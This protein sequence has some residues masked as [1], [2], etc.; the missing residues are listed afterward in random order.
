MGHCVATL[1]L[2]PGKCG[3]R[4]R[5]SAG[6]K[7]HSSADAH[8]GCKAGRLTEVGA[9]LNPGC[10]PPDLCCVRRDIRHASKHESNHLLGPVTRGGGAFLV[11]WTL[12][13]SSSQ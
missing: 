8:A 12:Y 1:G 9:G 5:F 11:P 7:Q 13:I 6:V 10:V 4:G 2:E 3:H